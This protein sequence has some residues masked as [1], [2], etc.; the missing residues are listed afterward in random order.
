MFNLFAIFLRRM[1]ACMPVIGDAADEEG[2]VDEENTRSE[3]AIKLDF[4]F[5]EEQIFEI[6]D[7]DDEEE[8]FELVDDDDDDDACVSLEWLEWDEAEVNNAFV[9]SWYHK[10]VEGRRGK[11]SSLVYWG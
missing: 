8:V 3:G 2:V 6:V 7:C 5:I 10:L 11:C 4:E 9:E 1:V